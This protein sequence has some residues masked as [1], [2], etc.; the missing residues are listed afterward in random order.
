M[1]GRALQPK[2]GRI[3]LRPF[4]YLSPALN[5]RNLSFSELAQGRDLKGCFRLGVGACGEKGAL[6]GL[7]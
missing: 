2:N 3:R 7:A 6:A 1:R 5:Q 4:F